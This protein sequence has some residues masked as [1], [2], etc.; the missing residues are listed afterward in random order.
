MK[1]LLFLYLLVGLAGC[2]ETQTG[3]D[4]NLFNTTYSKCVDY[5]TDS[6]KSP[7]SLKVRAANISINTANAEDINSVF[8][9]LIIKNGIIEENIKDEKARFRELLVNIDYEAQNSFG[10]SIRGLYQCK[11]ITRLNNA[12]TSPKPLNI[13]LHKLINDGEDI[14]LGVNIPISD[15]NGSNFSINSDIKKIVGTADSQLNETDIKRYKEIESI[16]EYKRLDNEAEKLRQSW[17]K[18]FS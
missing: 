3:L 18:S 15:L 13:Y 14:N 17:D 16:N 10:A 6:L 9:D 5:L 8:G 12:E 1:K 7:S 2:K 11:Y 4:K